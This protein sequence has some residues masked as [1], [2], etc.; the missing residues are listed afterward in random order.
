MSEIKILLI[1]DEKQTIK[2]LSNIISKHFK[3]VIT[4][5]DGRL[6]LSLYK[7]HQPDIVVSDIIM[8]NLDGL[9]LAN[10]IKS[11][12]KS[13]KVV[14]LSAYSEKEKLLKA[15]DVSVDKYLIKP[16]DPEA[17]LKVLYDFKEQ[18]CN[19]F[20]FGEYKLGVKNQELFYKDQKID[21]TKKEFMFLKMLIDAKEEIITLEKINSLWQKP[22]TQSSIRTFIKR[23]RDKLPLN[24]IKNIPST[25]YKLEI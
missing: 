19:F 11:I 25:G 24:I 8:P 10:E 1:E 22:P 12:N 5:S 18:S 3:N 14:I 6:G 23:L 7:K 2:L 15:I 13:T 9:S 21:L 17:L 20:S 4:A 16:I